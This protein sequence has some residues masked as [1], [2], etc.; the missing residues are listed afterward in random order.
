MAR[1][2]DPGAVM[3]EYATEVRLLTRSSIYAGSEGV[4]ANDVLIEAI[5]DGR[6]A[7]LLEVGCGTGRLAQRMLDEHGLAVRA[8]DIS[9]RMVE[10]ARAR[11]IDAR[12]ADV[13]AL[14]FDSESFDC[15]IA[16]WML[17]HVPD[18]DRGLAEIWRVL[19]PGGRLLAVTN[20]ERHLEELWQLVGIDRLALSFS[21][22]NGRAILERH[23]TT[24]EQCDVEGVVSFADRE[25]VWRYVA[26]SPA[27]ADPNRADRVPPLDA[28]LRATRRSCVLLA[29]KGS[30]P[31]PD[32]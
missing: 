3:E 7:D 15:V 8:V 20:S 23:F 6:S 2:D 12:V 21:S 31:K 27:I 29:E 30:S 25:H 24:V 17:Y 26:A 14:P 1:L 18:L 9:E 19:R 13:Q 11:G 16:A 4:D 32:R 10:L 22:E 5:V 28:P